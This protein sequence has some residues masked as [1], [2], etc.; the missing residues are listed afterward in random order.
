MPDYRHTIARYFDMW[1]QPDPAT[2]YRIIRRL[3]TEDAVSADP[4]TRVSGHEQIAAMVARFHED[5]AG[6]R[7]VPTG[8]IQQHHD[9]ACFHWQLR[10]SQE[11]VRLSGFDCIRLHEGR[12]ADL[13]GFWHSH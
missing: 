10:N 9:R 3:W 11:L 8:E 7:L 5:F 13:T 1:N 4:T 2:R 12:I 6:H